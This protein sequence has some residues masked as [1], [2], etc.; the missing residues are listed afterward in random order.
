[1]W[2]GSIRQ[3]KIVDFSRG[4]S[5][6]EKLPEEILLHK[7]ARVKILRGFIFMGLVWNWNT[8]PVA[9]WKQRS[10]FT[11]CFSDSTLKLYYSPLSFTQLMYENI[12]VQIIYSAN[13]TN[14]VT[15]VR[16]L[17]TFSENGTSYQATFYY[18]LIY[19]FLSYLIRQIFKKNKCFL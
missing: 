2:L 5:W 17:C 1:M 13:S 16:I 19:F 8:F 7:V 4:Q 18:S 10:V 12:N 14:H 11:F 6:I 9:R 3:S 15:S